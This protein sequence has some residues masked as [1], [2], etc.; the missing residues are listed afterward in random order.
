MESQQA[1]A[2]SSKPTTEGTEAELYAASA[3]ENIIHDSKSVSDDTSDLSVLTTAVE[4]ASISD[5]NKQANEG[6]GK[7]EKDADTLERALTKE[8]IV[9]EALNCPCIAAMRDGPCGDSFIAAYRCFLESETEP[10]GMDCMEQFTGMQSCIA[11]HPEEYN[12]DDEEEDPFAVSGEK[13]EEEGKR[14]EKSNVAS[15]EGEQVPAE[16]PVTTSS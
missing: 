1:S 12:I 8:E 9:E 10:K 2:P 14:A 6:A 7:G 3:T 13:K 4:S 15:K 5:E 16:R 11:E